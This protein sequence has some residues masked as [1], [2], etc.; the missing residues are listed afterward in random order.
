M[1]WVE[2]EL[3]CVNIGDERLNRRAKTLLKRLGA[4]PSASIPESCKG[5]QETEAAYRF[6]ENDLVTSKKIIKP[7]RQ[8]TLNRIKGHPVVLLL[9]DT[10][11]LNYSGQKER[12]DLGPL[13]QDNVRGIFLHPTLAVTPNRDCL[14]IIDYEQWSRKPLAHRS[15]KERKAERCS[16]AIKDKE[17]YRWVRGYKKA[18]CLA[19]FMPDTQFIYIADREGD[20]YDIY[21]EANTAFAKGSADWVIRATFD[22]A[23]L[24][25][26]HPKKSTKL[27]ANVKAS[28]GV[29][30]VTFTTSSFGSRKKREVTQ[31][32]YAKEVTLRPPREKA[33]EGFTPVQLTAIIATETNPPPGEKAIEWTLLTSIPIPN[34]EAALKV[35][36]WYLCRWQ[37][38]IF[39]KILKSGCTIEKLQL[40]NKQRFD[41]CLALYLIVAWRI[42]F[43]TMI[44]R[45]SPSLSSE[46]LFET[47]EWQTAYIMIYEKPP[48]HEP[49]TLKEM[50]GIIA[51]LGGFLGRKHDREPGPAVIWKGLRKLYN[52][53]NAREVF[54]RAFGHTYG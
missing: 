13:Q 27:K 1:E 21:H 39:F 43:M 52:C 23:I 9:Q 20:I 16:K 32:I 29:G 31:T 47:I 25:E 2:D 41:P 54:T 48:P 50:L 33:K 26:N 42:L 22:R 49:P 10:T 5:W 17:S 38:E 51:Q 44:G 36:H 3:G 34:L 6:F 35:I 37:I 18:S 14:G 45:A 19:K 28:T 4:N 15:A 7:H 24:D 11:T 8:A 46:C 12:E 30:Q 53:I 40:S